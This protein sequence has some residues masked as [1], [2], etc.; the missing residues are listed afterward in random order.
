[1]ASSLDPPD[2][3]MQLLESLQRPLKSK[4]DKQCMHF[5]K[6]EMQIVCFDEHTHTH[7][8]HVRSLCRRMGLVLQR[9]SE[10]ENMWP[11][12]PQV[13]TPKGPRVCRQNHRLSGNPEPET[14]GLLG[15]YLHHT[16]PSWEVKISNIDND[17]LP[18]QWQALLD[19]WRSQYSSKIY[20]TKFI[21]RKG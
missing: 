3:I 21:L 18:V 12:C 1:M 17:N 11:A 9:K 20:A 16:Y 4:H 5:S 10:K 15:L 8:V 19:S 6:W 13:F 7:Y 14:R 2:D